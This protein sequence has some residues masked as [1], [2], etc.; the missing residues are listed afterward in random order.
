MADVATRWYR[1]PEVM[2]SFRMYTKVGGWRDCTD[3]SLS[4]CGRSGASSPRWSAV[5]PCS[6]ERTSE[7]EAGL[8]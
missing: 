2:L 1:A 8:C 7:Y 6:R 5:D 3:S 4:T